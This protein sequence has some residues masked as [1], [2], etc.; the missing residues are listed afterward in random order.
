V[1]RGCGEI[2]VPKDTQLPGNPRC[3][4]TPK[5]SVGDKVKEWIKSIVH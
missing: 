3:M 5:P 2:A 4:S 1:Q